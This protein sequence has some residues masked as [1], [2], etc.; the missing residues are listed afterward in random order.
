MYESRI[1]EIERRLELMRRQM[2]AMDQK[3]TAL[4][5]HLNAAWR[6][7][8]G[9][10]GGGSGTSYWCVSPGFSAATGTW[11]SITPDT[12]TGVDIYSDVGGSMTL[13]SAGQDV[14]WW[15][16]DASTAGKLMMVLPTAD[17]LAWDAVVDSCTAI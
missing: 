3:L 15:Y 9:S 10:G 4:A 8:W 11:P 6:Q 14:Y 7:P 13:Y 12:A 2:E 16:K 1:L 17:G 5:Q